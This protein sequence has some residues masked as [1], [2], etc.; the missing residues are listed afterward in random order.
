MTN[1]DTDHNDMP[2]HKSEG[3]EK[4]SEALIVCIIMRVWCVI[5]S[6]GF[7]VAIHGRFVINNLKYLWNLACS[8]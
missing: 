4:E 1:S 2:F 8:V 3:S 7:G 6:G 5:N